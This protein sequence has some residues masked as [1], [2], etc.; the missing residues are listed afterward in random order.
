ML[1]IV[2]YRVPYVKSGGVRFTINKKDYFELVLISH[3]ARAG[4]IK[5]ISMKASMMGWMLMSRSWGLTSSLWHTSMANLSP[6]RSPLPMVQ[7]SSSIMLFPLIGNLARPFLVGFSFEI[8]CS[9]VRGNICCHSMRIR[10][11]RVDGR[12]RGGDGPMISGLRANLDL[13]PMSC[14]ML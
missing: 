14:L 8:P 5:P 11:H 10:V 6:S 4:S 2:E 3:V 1:D 12:P 9:I 13:T 7:P